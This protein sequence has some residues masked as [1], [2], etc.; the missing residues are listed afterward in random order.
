MSYSPK[1][2]KES[3]MTKHKHKTPKLWACC[4]YPTFQGGDQ[5]RGEDKRGPHTSPEHHQADKNHRVLIHHSALHISAMAPKNQKPS[6]CSFA[7]QSS[8]L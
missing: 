8:G 7:A 2:H 3:D 1:S 6:R 4:T 5:G